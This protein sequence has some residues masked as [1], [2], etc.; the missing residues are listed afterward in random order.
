MNA[1]IPIERVPGCTPTWQVDYLT[2][3]VAIVDA[4]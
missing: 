3:L 2:E 4:G 1:A